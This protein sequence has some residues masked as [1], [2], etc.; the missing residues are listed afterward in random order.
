MSH[1]AIE[2]LGQR[3]ESD[4]V[5][6]LDRE[7]WVGDRAVKFTILESV[8]GV[9]Q[10]EVP[11]LVPGVVAKRRIYEPLGRE[12]ALDGHQSVLVAH[13]GGGMMAQEE[14]TALLEELIWGA[15]AYDIRGEIVP[16]G[17]SLGG[18]RSVHAIEALRSRGYDIRKLLLEAPACFSGVNPLGA[19]RSV[20]G[21]L[22]H[23]GG[24]KAAKEIAVGREALEYAW[25]TGPTELI[26]EFIY[27]STHQV[28]EPTK[29][30]IQDGLKVASIAHRDDL[31]IR[32]AVSAKGLQR[33]GVEHIVEMDGDYVGHTAQLYNARFAAE[34]ISRALSTL[35]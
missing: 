19:P 7:L 14:V 6:K 26:K 10:A 21:E 13:E 16:V 4:G 24:A 30:L 20:F 15:S 34:A 1:Q 9:T 2:V 32:P 11:V 5:Y 25:H 27:A 18:G 35:R 17:H 33:A 31:L 8:K 23:M 3:I 29:E 12:L 22:R 28:I